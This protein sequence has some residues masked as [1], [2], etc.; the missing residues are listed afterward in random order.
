MK[1]GQ[2]K[3]VEIGQSRNKAMLIG[4]L[5]DFDKVSIYNHVNEIKLKAT[6]V[7]YQF[8]F[9]PRYIHMKD[10]IYSGSEEEQICKKS[11]NNLKRLSQIINNAN[12]DFQTNHQF[13]VFQNSLIESINKWLDDLYDVTKNMK[14]GNIKNDVGLLHDVFHASEKEWLVIDGNSYFSAIHQSY[15]ARQEF[16]CIPPEVKEWSKYYNLKKSLGKAYTKDILSS[17]SDEYDIQMVQ[18]IALVMEKNMT[19]WNQGDKMEF[20]KI[21][22]RLLFAIAYKNKDKWISANDMFVY[23]Q[24]VRYLTLPFD[25]TTTFKQTNRMNYILLTALYEND[26]NLEKT[27]FNIKMFRN[28]IEGLITK[29]EQKEKLDY[30]LDGLNEIYQAMIYYQNE[31]LHILKDIDGQSARDRLTKID[32]LCANGVMKYTSK[33]KDSIINNNIDIIHMRKKLKQMTNN[34]IKVYQDY[35]NSNV[36]KLLKKNPKLSK[37]ISNI[38][39][40]GNFDENL[41]ERDFFLLVMDALK[42]A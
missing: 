32:S 15:L 26:V 30:V 23:I 39:K 13:I 41:T 18:L 35:L 33:C 16:H 10:D 24:A 25:K 21:L 38:Y 28:L 12:K 27:T 20:M 31:S 42:C 37:N 40:L 17:K 2:F 19:S 5:P 8:N 1:K 29:N 36:T 3:S 6:E 7:E 14:Y 4:Y 34:M 9:N 22:Y 11:N